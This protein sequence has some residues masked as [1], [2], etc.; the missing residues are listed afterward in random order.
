MGY[1]ETIPKYKCGATLLYST[2]VGTIIK[3]PL[4]QA[5][6]F[7][8]QA[9]VMRIY[10]C[11][12]SYLKGELR[13]ENLFPLPCSP[14]RNRSC[15]L[16]HQVSASVKCVLLSVNDHS[17]VPYI[18]SGSVLIVNAGIIS[19]PAGNRLIGTASVLIQPVSLDI[20]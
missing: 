4:A 11:N 13:L 14:R 16:F 18:I 10:S 20:P 15:L 9:G 12:F 1:V 6:S 7:S 5:L 8:A 17:C 3:P 2:T 19:S